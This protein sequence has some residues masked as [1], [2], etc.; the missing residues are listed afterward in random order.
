M[1]GREIPLMVRYADIF[2]EL[3]ELAL[4][5]RFRRLSETMMEEGEELYAE[6][7][8]DFK[9]R[10]FPAFHALNR[11]APLAV[12]ELAAAL[13]LSHTAVANIV[14]EMARAGLVRAAGDSSGDR[15]R[16]LYA[17]TPKGKRTFKRLEPVW[18]EIGRAAREL[19]AETDTDL[20]SGIERFERAFARR[21]VVDRVRE[22]LHLPP[23][24]RLEIVDYRPA[25]KKH[26]RSLNEE[27][28]REHFAIEG[29]DARV[30]ADPMGRIVR[31]GGVV[32]FALWDGEVAGTCALRRDPTGLVELC[33]MAVRADL[34]RHGIGSALLAA[35]ME[36]ARSM[37][38]R[39]LYL[40]TSHELRGAIRLY[41]RAGFRRI[42][43]DPL[44]CCHMCR[45][46]VTMKKSLPNPRTN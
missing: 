33:K 3:R 19:L 26:F 45:E 12:G 28:L 24:R 8:V 4:A 41:R 30:L 18:R 37:G 44:G 46:S 17:L 22:R 15:R 35:A 11:R 20:L 13:G 40:R 29:E 43:R 2:S 25:Y 14:G 31:R 10:W 7:G 38:A 1:R 16:S 5:S 21:S 42:A 39:E 6:L 36:R 27:W 23:R 34:R 32:L 9:P